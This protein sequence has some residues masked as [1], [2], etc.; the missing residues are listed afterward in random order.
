MPLLERPFKNSLMA[1]GIPGAG[2]HIRRSD[3]KNPSVG[4]T[5]LRSDYL[6]CRFHDKG[7]LLLCQSV[8]CS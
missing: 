2:G 1:E 4:L 3:Q 5:S 6:L 7:G 8:A